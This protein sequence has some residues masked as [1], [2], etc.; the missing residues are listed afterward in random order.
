[1][2]TNEIPAVVKLWESRERYFSPEIQ[3]ITWGKFEDAMSLMKWVWW[4]DVS[5]WARLRFLPENY[6][7]NI[8]S[9]VASTSDS[10]SWVVDL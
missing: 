9:V 7:E 10:V 6:D 1:M 5:Y 8:L 2:N 4:H 3:E